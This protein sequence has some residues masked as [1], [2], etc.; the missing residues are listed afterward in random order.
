MKIIVD[1]T[2]CEANGMCEMAAP[3][4][5]FVTDADELEIRH[6]QVPKA[7]IADLEQAIRSCPRRALSLVE[8]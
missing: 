5:F 6:D 4:V 1:E 8:D 3:K 7:E 2:L